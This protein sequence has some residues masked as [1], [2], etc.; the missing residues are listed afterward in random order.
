VLYNL[1]RSVLCNELRRCSSGCLSK[2]LV[3]LIKISAIL[4]G[5]KD[6]CLRMYYYLLISCNLITTLVVGPVNVSFVYGVCM[7][8]R[9]CAQAV[10]LLRSCGWLIH[11]PALAAVLTRALYLF[12][13]HWTLVWTEGFLYPANNK[14]RSSA[15]ELLCLL[16]VE[17]I[18]YCLYC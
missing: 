18:Q 9:A 3:R 11:A 7:Y 8:L 6:V 4:F 1:K 14:Y 13:S 2:Q 5:A 16:L 17:T 10:V 15:R 12:I